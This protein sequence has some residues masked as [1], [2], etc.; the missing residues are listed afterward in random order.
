MFSVVFFCLCDFSPAYGQEEFIV[1][2]VPVKNGS[3]TN[4]GGNK[5]QVPSCPLTVYYSESS[6]QLEFENDTQQSVSFTYYLYGDNDTLLQFGSLN[7][8]ASGNCTLY[9]ST[10]TDYPDKIIVY[11]EG[12]AYEGYLYVE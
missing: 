6:M 12:I 5:S 7:L 11:I 10:L 3:G 1:T 4:F 2:L 9:L 8:N